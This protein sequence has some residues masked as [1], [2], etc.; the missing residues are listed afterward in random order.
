MAR[1]IA[2]I[3]TFHCAF[4]AIWCLT[5]VPYPTVN[6]T[7]YNSQSFNC[8][9]DPSWNTVAYNY[10]IT[11]I[12]FFGVDNGKCKDFADQS[13]GL[14]TTDCDDSTRTFYL[15]IN[16]VTD[17]YNEKTIKCIAVYGAEVKPK[18]ESLIHVQYQPT[19][20]PTITQTPVGPIIEGSKV[21]LTCTIQGGNPVATI[22]WSCDGATQI[23]PTGSPSTVDVISSVELV[24]SK[25]NNGQICTCT[26]R[27]LL[28]TNDKTQQHNIT[29]YYEPTS[30]PSNIQ[31]PLGPINEISTVIL[32]CDIKGGNPLATITW[33]CEGASPIN[34]TGN[35]PT[36]TVT[37]SVQLTVNSNYNDR[38]CTCIGHHTVW[39]TDKTTGHTLD[40][41]CK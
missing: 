30:T 17:E 18:K 27:H 38:I 37:A 36:N 23:T 41:R 4:S 35:P 19:K 33:T 25:N 7:R 26:G 39:T 31:T 10:G 24:T 5:L 14:Y 2:W 20:L 29:V 32:T 13:S 21:S 9:V 16:N 3:Y 28:W 34:L 22:T 40:V 11:N 6:V 12:A 8:S 15:T 1:C